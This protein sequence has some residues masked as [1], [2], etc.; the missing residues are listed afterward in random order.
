MVKK[1]N[2]GYGFIAQTLILF[3]SSVLM[4]MLMAA[5][6]GDGAREISPLYQMGSKGLASTTILEFLLSSA[7]ITALKELFFSEKIFKNLM[8]L[9][10]TVL[11]LFSVLIVSILFIIVFKWFPLNFG[12]AWAGF[13][14]CFGGSCV[15]VSIFLIIKTRIESKRYEE[16][17]DDYKKQHENSSDK[18]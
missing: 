14:I 16:L 13:L 5:L 8:T 10:R 1:D 3:A 17:L 6:F 4:M 11:M 9:W 18:E 12:L 7:I 15:A 2:R